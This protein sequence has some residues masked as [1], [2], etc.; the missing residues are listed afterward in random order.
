LVGSIRVVQLTDGVEGGRGVR[1]GVQV[2][3]GRVRDRLKGQ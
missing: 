1:G 3:G 2:E